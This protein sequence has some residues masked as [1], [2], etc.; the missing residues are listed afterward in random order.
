MEN[1]F[2]ELVNWDTRPDS[3]GIKLSDSRGKASAWKLDD[4]LAINYK[5]HYILEKYPL[6]CILKKK[7]DMGN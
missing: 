2:V 6:S 7:N 4:S 3:K 5:K 1:Y